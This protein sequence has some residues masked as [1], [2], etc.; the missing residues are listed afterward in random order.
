MDKIRDI[1]RL[2]QESDLSKRKISR[3]LNI[4]RPAVDHY[5]KKAAEAQLQWADV[6]EMD[7]EEL[8]QRLERSEEKSNDPRYAELKR[9]LP[10]IA[11]ELG[12]KH[13]TRQL[14]WEEY[15]TSHPDGYEYSQF[16]YHLQ[17]YTAD[18]ELAMH[19]SHEP[20][21]NLF[22]DFSGDRRTLTDPKT[23]IERKVELF[24]AVFP[25]GSLI[26]AEAV[27]SQSTEDVIGATR[28]TFEYAEGSPT[29]LVP[30][31]MKAAVTKADTYEPVINQS[32]ED[33]A[34][35]YGC[36]V[37]PARPRKPKDKALVEA[38][39]YVVYTRVLAPLRDQTFGTLDELNTAIWEKL[40]LLNER[41]MKKFDI[42]RRER[43]EKIE[44][45]L[46]A[47][48]PSRPYIIRHFLPPATVQKNYHVYFRPDGHYY[49]VPYRYRKK[50]VRIA[51]TADEVEI[52]Y[53]HTRIAAH[54][55]ERR[56]NGYT[57]THE[58]MPSQHKIVSEW[59]PQRFLN[60]ASTYGSETKKLISRV[61][62]SREVPEQ[63][64][65]SCLGILNLSKN[66][67]ASRLE[68]ASARANFF[69]IVSA[70]GMKNIL[71]KNLDR[72]ELPKEQQ[73]TLPPHENIRGHNYYEC[74]EGV[75]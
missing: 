36:A 11:K 70:K 44:K 42:S 29:T 67:S 23:G 8:L 66:Y 6:K 69:G 21:E 41:K 2:H 58:H 38:A 47:P 46:L 18:S 16:C 33:F 22:I 39:V 20:G 71:E 50:K 60:W 15:K 5:L 54:R 65:R 32:F 4:S 64:Y 63:A 59:N 55:R 7:D 75:S 53:N 28:S 12:K 30:D 19:L 74:G 35:Y 56:K 37:I 14:L 9:L 51:Y 57:T 17:M 40:D 48:L 34:R 3:A 72:H 52:Y 10:D 27:E 1:I 68:A 61:I 26:Y 25:A 31:N 73:L 62:T 49:S 24:V 43:F 13:V 45:P